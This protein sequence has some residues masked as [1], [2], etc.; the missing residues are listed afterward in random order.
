MIAAGRVSHDEAEGDVV[1]EGF[2]GLCAEVVSDRENQIILAGFE[3]GGDPSRLI[4]AAI[5]IGDGTVQS[6]PGET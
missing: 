1:E 3:R 5:G 2:L 4:G 6:P